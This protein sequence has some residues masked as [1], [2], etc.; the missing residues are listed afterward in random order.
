MVALKICWFTFWHQQQKLCTFSH[1][2]SLFFCHL[3]LVFRVFFL[4]LFLDSY[5]RNPV[6]R[7]QLEGGEDRQF[8]KVFEWVKFEQTTN[9]RL[10][11]SWISWI[12][13]I[14]QLLSSG[15]LFCFWRPP[16][17]KIHWWRFE[18]LKFM[19]T[20]N[21]SIFSKKQWFLIIS[22]TLAPN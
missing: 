21:L 5:F 11:L 13:W 17:S 8:C 14:V 4:L 10:C 7:T 22:Y 19:Q 18:K 6:A 15:L 3:F 1:S 9:S 16:S 12:E 20:V 2:F